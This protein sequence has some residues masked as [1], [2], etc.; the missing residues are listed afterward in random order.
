MHRPTKR[1]LLRLWRPF[2]LVAGFALAALAVYFVAGR[3]SELSGATAFLTQLRWV[4]LCL[5]AIAEAASYLSMASLQ[6]TLLQAGGVRPGVMRTAAI[7]FAG[8]SIQSALPAGSAFLVLYQFRQYELL[9][10]DEILAGWVV[11]ATTVVTFTTL[12]VLA[13]VALSLAASTGTTFDL[14]GAVLG[15]VCIALLALLAWSRRSRLYATVTSLGRRAEK[16]AG[17]EPGKLVRPLSYTVQRMRHVAP[18][19]RRWA[20][21]LVF[22]VG[23]WLT[24]CACLMAAFLAVGAQVPWQGLLLAYCGGQLAANLPI[25]PG[26]LGVVEGSLTVALVD[27]GG[28]RAATVAA[29]LVY[30]LVSF[31]SP[32]PVGAVCWAALARARRRFLLKKELARSALGLA[33]PP[34]WSP[35]L[36]EPPELDQASGLHGQTAMKNEGVRGS[37]G[38]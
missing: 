9:G 3:T 21:A 34:E 38:A 16:L 29:V 11:V 7:T 33:D 17:L 36:Q 15:V 14:V 27:F 10:A 31:W 8:S 35:E 12:S 26:G 25:T 13:A 18:S 24:D 22:G 19:R 6:R 28:G 4:P 30:R 2:R 23:S 1:S 32:L 5:A 20:L 37:E